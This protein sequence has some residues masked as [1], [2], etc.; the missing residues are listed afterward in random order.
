MSRLLLVRHGISGHNIDYRMAGCRSDIDMAAGGYRQVEQLR[1]RLAGE[2]IDAVYSSDMKRALATAEVLSENHDV[3]I[4]PCPELRE[5]DYGEVEGLTFEQISQQFPDVAELIRQ[6]DPKIQFPGGESFREFAARVGKFAD[7]LKKHVSS[8]TILVTAHGGTVRT[9]V[10]QLLGI[11]LE[12]W[13]Q[14]RIDNASLTIID[15]NPGGA[16][17]SLLNDTSHLRDVVS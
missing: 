15:T 11:G 10:C 17:I 7:R 9:L 16:I 4:I 13:R 3:E 12:H 5:I 6:Y 14:I 1:D 2:K 8:E